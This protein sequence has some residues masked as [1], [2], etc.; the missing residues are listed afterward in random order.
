MDL[1][2]QPRVARLRLGCGSRADAH[3]KTHHQERQQVRDTA[4]RQAT[5][6][7]VAPS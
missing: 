4:H 3:G 6:S 5:V 2:Q 7:H 1:G